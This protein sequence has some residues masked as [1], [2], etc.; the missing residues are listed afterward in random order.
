MQIYMVGGAVRDALLGLPVKDRDWVAVG[1][2]PQ[3]LVDLGYLPVGKDFPVFLH[4]VT[5]DEVALARQERKTA[6]GYHGFAF[7][8]AQDVTLEQDLSRR[9]LTINSIA[10]QAINTPATCQFDA[11]FDGNISFSLDRNHLVDPYGGLRDLDAKVLRHVSPAFAE[12]PVRILRLARFAARFSDF[13]V[14]PETMTLM[15]QM[16]Q[17]GEVDA[18]VSERVWQEIATGLMYDKP[19]RMFEVLR[20]C[21][22]LKR[23]LPE[24]DRLW[25][26][27]QRAE[28][29]PEIDTGVHAMMVLDMSARLDCNLAIRYAC[30]CHDFGKGTTPADVLPRHIGHEDRSV[31]LLREVSARLRVPT[32]C[33]ELAEVVARE[34]GNIHRS[35]E[36]SAAAIV[37]LLERC[38]AFRKPA[39]FAEVLLACECDARGRLGFEDAAYPQRQRL[40]Q[41]LQA[42][43]TV[44]AESAINNIAN[45]SINTPARGKNSTKNE[46]SVAKTISGKQIGEM[47]HAARVKAVQTSLQDFN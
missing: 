21:G 19:S 23:L 9:D 45:E 29:H 8:A 1:A 17:N 43:Q 10:V 27:P 35:S 30:L 24:L 12:D 46:P 34:H 18:L 42:A 31:K 2:T 11:K 22:A 15:C 39:R 36:F 37:R 3:Q 32:E 13:T 6:P 33:K 7:H 41:S 47:M 38:D 16:V 4:P 26:V 44:T 40:L 25:G 14:A 20:E 28:Y 5:K